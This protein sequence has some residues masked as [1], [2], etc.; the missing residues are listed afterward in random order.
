MKKHQHLLI[1]IVGLLAIGWMQPSPV[2]ATM[3]DET[4]L[5][6]FMSESVP[7]NIMIILDN[8]GSM[9]FN[10]YGS[11]PG[12]G[13][14]VTDEPYEGTP[15]S[16]TRSFTI[17]STA[18][19]MEQRFTDNV[20]YNGSDDLD[21]GEFIAGMRFQNVDIPQ[22]STVS[23]ASIGFI[24]DE[25]GYDTIT[26]RVDAEASDDAPPLQATDNNIVGGARTGTTNYID[27][28]PNGWDAGDPYST[29]DLSAVVQELVDRAGW[30]AGNAMLFRVYTP[31]LTQAAGKR[32]AEPRESGSGVAPILR[33]TIEDPGTGNK[34][35]YG[36]F[37]PDYFYR[38]NTSS[39]LFEY[40]Y[41]KVSYNMTAGSWSVETMSGS[42]SSITNSQIATGSAST[43]LWDGNW[44]NWLCM[45][46][47]DVLRKVLF[48][49]DTKDNRDG[50]GH[51]I[52]YG[53]S[54]DY[55]YWYKNFDDTV[56][57]VSPFTG[58]LSYR[59]RDGYIRANGIDFRIRVEK[60]ILYEPN[61]FHNYDN[62]DNLAGI[63]Q[64]IWNM[65]Q[66]GNMWFRSGTGSGNNGG[67]LDNA[68]GVDRV[69]LVYDLERRDPTTWTPLAE[70][71]YTAMQY[72][73]QE[74]PASGLGYY[75]DAIPNDVKGDSDDP[76]YRDGSPVPCA[77]NY[78]ILLTDGASTQD[79]M[80][81]G[82]FKDYDGDG[83]Q[84]GCVEGSG[85]SCDYP[86]YGTDF[87]DD[88]ALYA[89]T[90]DLRLESDMVDDQTITLYTIYAFG[91]DPN[92]RGLLIDAAKNGGFVDQDGDKKPDSN[93]D[94]WDEDGDG[95]PDTYYEANDGYAL[96]AKLLATFGRIGEDAASGSSASVLATNSEG[97]GQMV[98]AYFRAEL[99]DTDT[100]ETV[101]WLGYLQ[102]FWVDAY[103]NIREDTIQGGGN[104]TTLD[105]GDQI[106][107][108]ETDELGNTHI[109]KEDGSE[110]ELHDIQPIFE[111]GERLMKR[112][113]VNFPRRIFTF[114]DDDQDGVVSET[115][116]T[117]MFDATGE[118][119]AF[120]TSSATAIKPYLDVASDATYGTGG[121][122]LGAT[123]DERVANI[124]EWVR[125][126]DIAGLRNRTI[127]NETWRLG[128]I[129]Q[130]T[131]VTVA[132]PPDQYHTIYSD[133]SYLTYWNAIKDRETMIYVGSNDGMLHAFTSWEYD[134]LNTSYNKPSGADAL[135]QI[136]DEVWAFIPQAVLPHLKYV[137]HANYTHTYL[138]DG[139][140]RVFDAKILPS[141]TH[142]SGSG[143]GDSWGTFLVM[144]LNMGARYYAPA[145]G[146]FNGDGILEDRDFY[147][148]YF[149]LDITDPR[150]P[151]LMWER[152]YP[153]LGMS[154]SR[155][156]PL[157]VGDEWFLAFGSGP[158]QYDGT[159]NQPGYLYIVDMKTGQ[160]IRQFGPLDD[161]AFF[162]DPVAFDK[163]LNY[164][165]DAI[166]TSGSHIDSSNLKGSIY[167][168]AVPCSNCEW[169]SGYNAAND[170]G[171]DTNPA[172][173][174]LSKIFDSDR[175]ITAP[176]S[177]STEFAPTDQIDN[178]WIY[179]GTGR[180]ITDT[181]VLD[182]DQEYLYGI[183]DPFFNTRGSSTYN[184][185]S[186]KLITRDDLLFPGHTI[187]TTTSGIVFQNGSLYGSGNF[188]EL[189]SD[190][191]ENYDG[192]YRPL[193]TNGTLAAERMV[194]KPSV[195]GGMVFMP[196]FTPN[197]NVCQ[198]GGI[199]NFYAL[200]FATGTGYIR[201]IFEIETPDTITYN[202]EE[203][204]VVEVKLDIDF[205]GTPPPTA[206]MHAGL[207]KGA[208]AFIQQST[209]QV[210]Q[211]DVTPPF[212]F[213][214]TIIDWWER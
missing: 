147:P 194:S 133:E 52:L 113:I 79:S 24:A 76:F 11:W 77:K 46:R 68:M 57:A 138:V 101:K 44:L 139:K 146:D 87:L 54:D 214:S 192:W 35:Y 63:V 134:R 20:T 88:L 148:T 142:Y 84:T 16:S 12:S 66:W 160:M 122:E 124:I 4:A 173:W 59:V 155:P 171:Y 17:T 55:R 28:I 213:Q 121:L 53:E 114:V 161:L 22:G 108:F 129:I 209:G 72:F 211:L 70:T 204:E 150:N 174:T 136:G 43:G 106:I 202:S 64:K 185:S 157:K 151:R 118:A 156:T 154:R 183:K 123:H 74:Y 25:N 164:N 13:S 14:T 178:V 196:V 182:S 2:E 153:D 42:S 203:H 198:F 47:I 23:A 115:G 111:A 27:W 3:A 188:F 18:D 210:L 117:T 103:G 135:E 140:P 126:T 141:G 149:L 71:F 206:G 26:L 38:Y 61:D 162:N 105:E 145:R 15:Y 165:V 99:E 39:G 167:K 125:G 19:D 89:H 9:N 104:S 6:V 212:Y 177:V 96:E 187:T 170:F 73:R 158:I 191:R 50:S 91:N 176:V 109:V 8:S 48:G 1:A 120:T 107:N 197:D 95:L 78:V 102:S 168:I 62:G 80:I 45:R 40:A 190:I 97:E 189:E 65:A 201:Q 33:I 137:A 58:N 69:E 143:S 132:R 169:D 49:G 184:Y 29:D 186:T 85:S 175:P 207:E 36:Y 98:Q 180:Y 10:A 144:G 82:E 51:Q 60:N 83:D 116:Y 205:L 131:P 31:T 112:D 193:E 200:Y 94:E 172:N 34:R 159:S 5:P 199:T 128:D 32:A 208:K 163:G 181:D 81:P 130:S 179:F 127:K 152:S 86:S 92:A 37:N 100:N 93:G 75:S 90:N 119:I 21:F 41:K 56:S 67:F 110:V 30:Q 166:Y 7:P 195:L